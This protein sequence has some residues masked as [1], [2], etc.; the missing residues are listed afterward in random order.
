[1]SFTDN[2]GIRI[3]YEVEGSGPPLLLLHGT[4][5]STQDWRQN[6]FL[7]ALQDTNRLVMI[8]LRGHGQSDKPHDVAHYDWPLL[9][10]DVAH[11]MDD[12]GLDEAAVLGYSGGSYVA[13]GMAMTAAE[14]IRA[15]ILGGASPKW[16]GVSARMLELLANGMEAFVSAT[17]DANGPLNPAYRAHILTNDPAALSASLRASRCT[18]TEALLRAFTKPT[19]LYAGELDPRLADSAEMA[20]HLKDASL[21]TIPGLNHTEAYLSG[22]PA[23]PHIKA[24]LSRLAH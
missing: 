12:L 14:R 10:A 6:G 7:S 22:G 15:L 16:P 4:A 11:V 23:L 18:P 2:D 1:M 17:L 21:V 3:H 20:S 5:G 8:D 24:F 19:L 9:V 13:L